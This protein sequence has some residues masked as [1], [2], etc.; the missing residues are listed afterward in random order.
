[1]EKLIQERYDFYNPANKP[2]LRQQKGD[3]NFHVGGNNIKCTLYDLAGRLCYLQVY[4]SELFG[5]IFLVLF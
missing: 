3:K 1:M 2:T 4:P 5:H